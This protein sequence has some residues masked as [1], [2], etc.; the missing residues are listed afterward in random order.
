MPKN[1]QAREKKVQK[2]Q[3]G[4]RVSGRSIFVVRDSQRKRDKEK[5]GDSLL[6]SPE[7]WDSDSRS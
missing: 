2:R 5:I 3:N 1:W 6:E 4:M 7:R